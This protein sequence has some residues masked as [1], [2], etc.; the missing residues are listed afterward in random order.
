MPT[1]TIAVVALAVSSASA[2]FTASNMV[3]SALTYRRVRPKVRVK[4][5]WEWVGFCQSIKEV[6]EEG[7]RMG[8]DVHVRSMSPTEIHIRSVEIVRRWRGAGYGETRWEKLRYVLRRPTWASSASMP[9][10]SP[11]MNIPPFGGIRWKVNTPF[12]GMY[13]FQRACV[14]ITL[15][16][17]DKA[18]SQWFRAKSSSAWRRFLK[19]AFSPLFWANVR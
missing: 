19:R 3:V 12:D 10:E 9:D 6:R 7:M 13:T 17:G 1:N 4:A 5:K 16:N 8:F 2:A 11:A 15:T 14:E 18:R